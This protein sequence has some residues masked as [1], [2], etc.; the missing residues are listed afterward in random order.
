MSDTDHAIHIHLPSKM[1]AGEVKDVLRAELACREKE[2]YDAGRLAGYEEGLAA[3]ERRLTVITKAA[4][5]AFEMT[6][7]LARLRG[8]LHE[9]D[10][11]VDTTDGFRTLA[12]PDWNAK[13]K[14]EG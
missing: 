5:A 8:L 1:T 2:A 3:M 4:R 9:A 6:E 13:R 12:E 14:G 10:R 11:G 7:Q